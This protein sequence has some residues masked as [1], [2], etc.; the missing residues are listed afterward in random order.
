MPSPMP[1][2]QS[3]HGTPQPPSTINMR[4]VMYQNPP[5]PLPIIP[6][7]MPNGQQVNMM[8]MPNG[9]M[10]PVPQGMMMQQIPQANADGVQMMQPVP[11]L[12]YIE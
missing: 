1:T 9:Q 3:H 8:M 11:H 4:Q 12:A 5:T 7:F 6:M 10:T 2:P